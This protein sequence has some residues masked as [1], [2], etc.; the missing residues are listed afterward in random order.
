MKIDLQFSSLQSSTIAFFLSFTN[1]A[2]WHLDFQISN[3]IPLTKYVHTAFK[4]THL[5][6]NNT[7]HN[8]GNA[9]EQLGNGL[10]TLLRMQ[11][12]SAILNRKTLIEQ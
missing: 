5:H 3:R 10:D 11:V 1:S 7:N 4:Y 9:K 8:S 6:P 12:H 2:T